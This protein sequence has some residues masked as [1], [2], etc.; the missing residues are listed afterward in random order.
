MLQV[1]VKNPFYCL[2]VTVDATAEQRNSNANNL[3]NNNTS[4]TIPNL[5]VTRTN[6]AINNALTTL[7][8]PTSFIQY[9]LFWFYTLTPTQQQAFQFVQNG[10][11]MQ[12]KQLL[13]QNLE[14]FASYISLATINF[15][16]GNFRN[17]IIILNYVLFEPT[18]RQHFVK[19]VAQ[20]FAQPFEITTEELTTLYYNSISND[21]I[22]IADLE[23]I[24]DD[25]Y[26]W[27]NNTIIPSIYQHIGSFIIV[28]YQQTLESVLQNAQ[29]QINDQLTLEQ[30]LT[31]IK[32]CPKVIKTCDPLLQKV[33]KLTQN[34][35]VSKQYSAQLCS[36]LLNAVVTYFN[37]NHFDDNNLELISSVLQQARKYVTSSD[38]LQTYKELDTRVHSRLL[39]R[40]NSSIFT[41]VKQLLTNARAENTSNNFS[42]FNKC[43]N[44]IFDSYL[45]LLVQLEKEVLLQPHV[46]QLE[47]DIASQLLVIANRIYQNI[48]EAS[49][50]IKNKFQSTGARELQDVLNMIESYPK[51][52]SVQ[53]LYNTLQANVAPFLTTKLL[54][55]LEQLKAQRHAKFTAAKLAP[56]TT[57]SEPQPKSQPEPQSTVSN[58]QKEDKNQQEVYDTSSFICV[59]LLF[60]IILIIIVLLTNIDKLNSH[61]T[62]TVEQPT[63]IAVEQPT[64]NTVEQPTRNTVEQLAK[65]TLQQ[66]AAY[67]YPTKWTV[68]SAKVS[69][70]QIGIHWSLKNKRKTA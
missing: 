41:Q 32:D 60:I 61:A 20:Q 53:L 50:R 19:F 52:D 48:A 31:L 51:D 39:L 4:W 7:A 15:L 65:N 16:E 1:L 37:D 49:D 40:K 2:A 69:Y 9:A 10:K 22:Q 35:E 18:M 26:S 33:Q 8:T 45:P 30:K 12:A 55:K 6:D 68:Q 62:H 21:D 66:P 17:G 57:Q 43:A 63:K 64:R 28:T 46:E 11:F 38:A 47:R 3:Q 58:T 5:P 59:V 70:L 56:T 13:A 42:N 24:Y 67:V 29:K 44:R 14:N 54:K 36:Y 23:K 25:R 34:N 27:P